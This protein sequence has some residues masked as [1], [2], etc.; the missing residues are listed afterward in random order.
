MWRLNVVLKY[1]SPGN[2]VLLPWEIS[3]ALNIF[4]IFFIKKRS[5]KN[6]WHSKAMY[7]SI[8]FK[9]WQ[10]A[11]IKYFCQCK[12]LSSLNLQTMQQYLEVIYVVCMERSGIPDIVGINMQCYIFCLTNTPIQL[13]YADWERTWEYTLQACLL[14]DNALH[15]ALSSDIWT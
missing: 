6:K 14:Q 1:A 11:M 9:V 12:H 4:S 2:W 5:H 8:A 3:F 15:W 10:L 7:H 13:E